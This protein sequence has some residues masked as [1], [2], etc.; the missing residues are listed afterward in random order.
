MIQVWLP[1]KKDSATTTKRSQFFRT[2]VRIRSGRVI[3]VEHDVRESAFIGRM[4][5]E[6]GMH[7]QIAND[8]KDAVEL[9]LKLGE[10]PAMLVCDVVMPGG[11]G[12]DVVERA[13]ELFPELPILFVSGY[14]GRRET[15]R[16][17]Y[18]ACLEKPFK[19]QE[20]EEAISALLG[21]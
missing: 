13:R 12:F 3:V 10:A 6:L 7:V 16:I 11:S 14:V 2:Q 5:S 8:V 4:L 20:L 15:S 17:P 9:L 19:L 18:S 1:L 21:S